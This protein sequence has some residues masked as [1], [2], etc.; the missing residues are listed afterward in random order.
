MCANK[1]TPRA[2]PQKTVRKK[3]RPEGTKRKDLTSTIAIPVDAIF[4]DV[5]LARRSYVQVSS[6][7]N[8]PYRIALT[9]EDML[10][11]R[12]PKCHIPLTISNVSREHAKLRFDGEEYRIVDLNS[13]NGTFVNN[14]RV[15]SCILRNHDQIRIGE[16]VIVFL[17]EKS[18]G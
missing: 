9:E 13:T 2:T 12:E 16:A 17:R 5:P 7:D 3:C 1:R 6:P 18:Q 8:S 15:S 11:G 14:V 10:I 4:E